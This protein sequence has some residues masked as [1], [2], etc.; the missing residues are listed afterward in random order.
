MTIDHFQLVDLMVMLDWVS[1]GAMHEMN[2]CH[3]HQ[4]DIECHYRR[5]ETWL[6]TNRHG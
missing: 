4:F 6:S 3:T 1:P 2:M 5:T